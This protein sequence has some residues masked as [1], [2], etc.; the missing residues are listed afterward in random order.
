[1]TRTQKN[2][3][4]LTGILLAALFVAY[5]PSLTGDF[6]WDDD[7]YISQNST[8]KT[9]QGL[10]DIWTKLGATP[11]YY[12]LTF[13]SFWLQYQLWDLHPTG[14][15]LI[16]VL[17]H[18][19][20]AVLLA[21]LLTRLSVPGAWVAAFL[22]AL[23]PAMV[24]SVA[25]MTEHKNTLS[26]FFYLLTLLS[27]LKNGKWTAVFFACALL[28]KSITMTL[29][30]V[31]LALAF[32]MRQRL[33]FRTRR[34]LWILAGL[35][36]CSAAFTTYF[37]HHIVRA[38]GMTWELSLPERLGIAGKA[39]WFYLGKWL[40]PTKLSFIYPRWE[41]L[42]LAKVWWFYGGLYAAMMVAL[43]Y[44]RKWWG[45]LP[46]A[47]MMF[48]TIS[49][50]PVLGLM[51]FYFMRF[52]FVADHFQYLSSLGLCALAGVAM[53]Q[54]IQ[55]LRLENPRPVEGLLIGLLCL[56]M[57]L[58]TH[59][60][61][62]KY[63]DPSTLWAHTL[64]LNPH[65]AIAHHHMGIAYAQKGELYNAVLHLRTAE[66]FDASYPETHLALALLMKQA[67]RSKE[68]RH[69]YEEAFRLGVTDPQ[70]ISDYRKLAFEQRSRA[71]LPK[72]M[73]IRAR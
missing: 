9:T 63:A 8:L 34:M 57:A 41:P 4:L 45:R 51:S 71:T 62:K 13:T 33:D 47:C 26:T 3:G 6:L 44:G 27:L 31:C 52:S 56:N 19:L 70:I 67:G 1:M 24:E 12:P 55:A 60:Q 43:A 64:E 7:A 46:L 17:F 11:Q 5:Q 22:F 54:G 53:T 49:I 36:V 58:A 59:A 35:A 10:K 21:L 40:W 61:S 30:F 37:E 25:W 29:P 20:N 73:T 42:A 38:K 69:Q 16:N 68:A 28:S 2:T 32:W 65:S 50:V 48:Y 18:G 66:A 15:H 23:H 14:Y 72:E 39:C